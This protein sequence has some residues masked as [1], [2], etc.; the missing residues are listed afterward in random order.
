MMLS[1]IY[2]CFVPH[3]RDII[4]FL[5]DDDTVSWIVL[6]FFEHNEI[7]ILLFVC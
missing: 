4:I 5:C 2:S 7:L 6:L 3:F 1:F